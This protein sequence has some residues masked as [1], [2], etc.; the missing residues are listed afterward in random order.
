MAFDIPNLFDDPVVADIAKKHNK[1]SAQILLRFLVQ[2]EIVVIPK[3]TNSE[4]LRQN[5]DVRSKV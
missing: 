4:R 5:I 3:S 2:Q 1:T